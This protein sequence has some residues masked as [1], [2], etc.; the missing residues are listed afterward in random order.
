MCVCS[1]FWFNSDSLRRGEWTTGSEWA[2][3]VC[4]DSSPR[5][6]WEWLVAKELW[7]TGR[8]AEQPPTDA[9]PHDT[10]ISDALNSITMGT[11]HD[12]NKQNEQQQQQHP[13]CHKTSSST[14]CRLTQHSVKFTITYIS[15]SDFKGYLSLWHKYKFYQRSLQYMEILFWV[16]SVLH[17]Y[18]ALIKQHLQIIQC[19]LTC[20]K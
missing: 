14:F 9:P 4:I 10:H 8:H 7:G 11:R 6:M 1:D 15:V 12:H 5:S 18:Q 19:G 20:F 2:G 3:P 17:T 16:F 13:L